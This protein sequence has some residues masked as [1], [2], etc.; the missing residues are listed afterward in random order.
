MRPNALLFHT[1]DSHRCFEFINYE[2]HLVIS[3]EDGIWLG[4]GMY[5]W[6]NVSNAKYWLRIK[7]KSN[8]SNTYSIVQANV[9]LDDMLDLTDIDIC[10]KMALL[11]ESYKD[12]VEED[13]SNNIPL[14]LKL[15]VLYKYIQDFRSK[16][17]VIRVFGKYN[18]TPDNQFWTYDLTGRIIE[19]ISTIKSIYNIKDKSAIADRQYYER[20][21]KK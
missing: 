15:N 9:F 3:E 18:R 11:W 2:D 6:D 13:D 20:R 17:P 7:Q 21:C 4:S 14:G 8:P 16:Y 1:N 19:P 5:F 12:K 10:N